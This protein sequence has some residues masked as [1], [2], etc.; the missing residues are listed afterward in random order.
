MS[1][2]YEL[3]WIKGVWLSVITYYFVK[4]FRYLFYENEEIPNEDIVILVYFTSKFYRTGR[5]LWAIPQLTN[6]LGLAY[7]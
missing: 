2:D 1:F 7:L 5:I 6:Y 4:M 3:L